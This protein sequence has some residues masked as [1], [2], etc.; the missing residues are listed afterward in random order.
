MATSKQVEPEPSVE[1]VLQKIASIKVKGEGEG[2]PLEGL[3]NKQIAEIYYKLSPKDRQL[4]R[5]FNRFINLTMTCTAMMHP[6]I[7]LQEG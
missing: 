5:Q 4:F 2:D 3:G 7:S 1:S 6:V